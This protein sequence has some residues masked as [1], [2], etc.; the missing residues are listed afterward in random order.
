MTAPNTSCV[1]RSAKESGVPVKAMNGAGKGVADAAG[2][3]VDV[4]VVVVRLVDD[5]DDVAPVEAAGG[6]ARR[7]ARLGCVELLQCRAV[8]AAGDP[9][10]QRGRSAS[11]DGT[12]IGV[13]VSRRERLNVSKSCVSSSVRSV[14]TMSVGFSASAQRDEWA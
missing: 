7:R 8:D 3:A 12:W 2:E 1:S 5:H 6:R 14:T 11:R 13:S 9:V 10:A 4:V